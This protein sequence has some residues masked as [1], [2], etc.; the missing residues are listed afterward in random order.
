MQAR[1]NLNK[2]N[3]QQVAHY[4][5]RLNYGVQDYLTIQSI[6]SIDQDQNLVLKA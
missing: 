4:V 2:T 5:N 6:W 1:C 3:D